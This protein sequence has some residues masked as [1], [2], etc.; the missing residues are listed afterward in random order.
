MG[1][2]DLTGRVALVTGASKGIGRGIVERFAEQG[3]KVIVSS[4]DQEACDKVASELNETYGKGSEIAIGLA[5][6][7]EDLDSLEALVKKSVEKWGRIDTLICNASLLAFI[8]PSAKTPQKYFTRLMEANIQ[9]TFRLCHLVLPQMRE[10]KDGNIIIIGSGSG[11][12]A[13]ANEFAYGVTKAAQSHLAR[14]L[15]AEVCTDNI[16]VNCVAAGLT[17]SFSSTP[18][19]K[20]EKVLETFTRK[21]PIQRIGEPDDIAAGCIFLSAPGGSYVTG[22]TINIDG[23]RT[24]LPPPE[25]L[26]KLDK[27]YKD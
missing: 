1:L 12:S 17:R 22:I 7:L 3:A 5:A 8:G 21:I 26:P 16:T 27:L 18:V 6:N 10:R 15:A 2:F 14:S 11:H 23:G 25:D 9:N 19:W 13:S 24:A 20:D 4:R